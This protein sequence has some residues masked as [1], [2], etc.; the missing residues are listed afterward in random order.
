MAVETQTIITKLEADVA[1][2]KKGLAESNEQLKALAEGIEEVVDGQDRLKSAGDKALG[3]LEGFGA[4]GLAAAEAIKKIPD[5]AQR[6]AKALEEVQRQQAALSKPAA[7]LDRLNGLVGGAT[8][9][10][11][12]L[13]AALGPVGLG[14]G[15]LTTV[16]LGG[17]AAFGSYALSAGKAYLETTVEG[18]K[19]VD[20][21]ASAHKGLESAVGETVSEVLNLGPAMDGVSVLLSRVSEKIRTLEEDTRRWHGELRLVAGVLTG[22]LSEA[23]L[24]TTK[25]L[26]E[27]GKEA[28]M[29]RE[30][31][32][33]FGKSVDKNLKIFEKFKKARQEE[34]GDE[35]KKL[36]DQVKKVEQ[37]MGASAGAAKARRDAAARLRQQ[38]AEQ[39]RE[40]RLQGD[41][42]AASGIA[43]PAQE[44]ERQRRERAA[45]QERDQRRRADERRK[46]I[47]EQ[48][49]R[50]DRGA[51]LYRQTATVEPALKSTIDRSLELSKA[52]N[53]TRDA[54][55][56]LFSAMSQGLADV[57]QGGGAFERLARASGQ[58]TAQGLEWAAQAAEARAALLFFEAPWAAVG[59][60]AAAVAARVAAGRI[61]Q[62]AGGG[63]GR[64]G[65]GGA[66][67][68]AGRASSE[69]IP[70]AR[71]SGLTQSAEPATR[72]LQLTVRIDAKDAASAMASANNELIEQGY[73]RA[74]PHRLIS[75]GRF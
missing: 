67:P 4:K 15:A 56:G 11:G 24:G 53:V 62:E 61:A 22:G 64:G 72:T 19:Q 49:R 21:L 63:A 7:G 27:L 2:Y 54:A 65:G 36:D 69:G 47:E 46:E 1:D 32:E 68:S 3:V 35:A 73:Y 41:L 43:A 55:V 75:Q 28:Q 48:F 40:S 14:V 8:G 71:L 23:L 17:A 25:G 13:S 51:D 20:T 30:Q 38:L 45:A 31:T 16:V 50:A 10:L 18:K 9:E 39:D 6:A 60:G 37:R 42:G 26:G 59:Y 44:L 58:A 33:T 57:D 70:G 66:R 12:K 34:G 5:P 52:L 74:L 29:A